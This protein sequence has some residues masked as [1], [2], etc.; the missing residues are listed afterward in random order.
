VLV[1]MQDSASTRIFLHL[2]V[3]LIRMAVLTTPTTSCKDKHKATNPEPIYT[4]TRR[5]TP[6]AYRFRCGIT[7]IRTVRSD[8]TESWI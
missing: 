4:L 6:S 3:H 5:C 8:S 7:W 1:L 2:P